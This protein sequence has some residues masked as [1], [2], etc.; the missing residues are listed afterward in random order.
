M[1]TFGYGAGWEGAGDLHLI[2]YRGFSASPIR[3]T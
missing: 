1:F 3:K 2:A